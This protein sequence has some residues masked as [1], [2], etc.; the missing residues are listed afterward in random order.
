MEQADGVSFLFNHR[1]V[2]CGSPIA[3]R[4]EAIGEAIIKL[5][6]LASDADVDGDLS[7]LYCPACLAEVLE[8]DDSRAQLHQI[9][10][11]VCANERPSRF[12]K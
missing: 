11:A 12:C 10:E 5:D 7:P 2:A 1:C 9:G 8:L 3:L 6:A 4:H